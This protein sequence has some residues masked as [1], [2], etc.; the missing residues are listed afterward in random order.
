MRAK[1]Y[2]YMLTNSLSH[3]IFKMKNGKSSFAS[4]STGIT[5]FFQEYNLDDAKS[6]LSMGLKVGFNIQ[7]I[8]ISGGISGGGCQGLLN[9]FGSKDPFK[10]TYLN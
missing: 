9:E 4:L 3:V 8:P 5:T 10:T 2:K 1:K 6:C 7:G